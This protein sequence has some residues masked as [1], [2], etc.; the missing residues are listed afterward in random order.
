M[1]VNDFTVDGGFAADAACGLMPANKRGVRN[2]TDSYGAG[3]LGGI[4]LSA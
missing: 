1:A 2:L 3:S 4:H